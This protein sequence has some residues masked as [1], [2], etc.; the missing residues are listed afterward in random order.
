MDD[1][2]K[3]YTD[4]ESGKLKS[5]LKKMLGNINSLVL[6]FM[7]TYDNNEKLQ[8]EIQNLMYE[9][10]IY[11]N[12]KKFQMF[13]SLLK[14]SMDSVNIEEVED[15]KKKCLMRQ[16]RA[17]EFTQ[18][19][20]FVQGAYFKALPE[21]NSNA[22]NDIHIPENKKMEPTVHASLKTNGNKT[23]EIT[24][25]T[26]TTSG[27]VL[28]TP[29]P[30]VQQ[31]IV[32]DDDIIIDD[33]KIDPN[34]FLGKKQKKDKRKKKKKEEQ[35][36]S[37]DP[38][39]VIRSKIIFQSCYI[40]KAKFNKDNVHFFYTNLCTNCGNYNYS[41]R[42][43]KVDLN[44]R[45]AVVTGGRVK[46]GYWIVLKLLRYG[47]K[48]ISTT[49]FPKDALIKYQQ[50]ADYES[51]KDNLVIYPIDFRL[52]ESTEKFVQWLNDNFPHLD[53]L[54]NN[55]AQTVRRTTSYYKYLLPI[56]SAP[57]KPEEEEKIIRN[58][59]TGKSDD[60]M[61]G[62]G[63]GGELVSM[64]SF[65]KNSGQLMKNLESFAMKNNLPLS[66]VASQI[67]VMEEKEG[68][69]KKTIMGQDGQPIDF[70][71]EKS[72]WNMELDE[73]PLQE[74]TE[75]QIINAWTPY[76]LCVKLKSLMEKSP[77]PDRYIVN[78]SS[79]E[80]IF[81]HFKRTTHP[82]TNMAKAALNMMTR[83]CGRYYKGYG[84][85]MTGVDTG[86]VS[87]MNEFNN[88]F[89]DN[90]AQAFEQE[91]VNIPLD[92]LDGAMRC[93]HPIIE[94]VINKNFIYGYLLKDYK[95]TNW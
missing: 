10:Q 15:N 60:N 21:A 35:A 7:K 69:N 67:K 72:S 37:T 47:C 4:D 25:G 19:K 90:A 56:E 55:A 12:K 18:V 62:A 66:V 49:R 71:D 58:D 91:Y 85:Y 23:A 48:V 79:V 28:F 6:K 81:N 63:N 13:T 22:S 32:D 57:L 26:K 80:G 3:F 27:N 86:W 29:K 38:T 92:E 76:Y 54:I 17:E 93:I 1:T 52:F 33:V 30:Q 16:K 50:E 94:G 74:F 42:E 78:V 77:F 34:Q 9:D 43:M 36:A 87:P 8:P 39:Q 11:T 68:A 31:Q 83:T 61:L 5:D 51:F 89:K 45:I 59:F 46:I 14:N 70:S 65:G 82:H 88:I 95:T 64:S 2:F 73:V 20:D 84:I 53:I 44:G 40:C 41:F 75:V 24:N